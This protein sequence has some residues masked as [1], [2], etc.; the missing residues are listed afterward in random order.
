MLYQ[1]PILTV[2]ARTVNT[3]GDTIAP[4]CP[5]RQR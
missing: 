1:V 5:V 4:R 3:N 2:D